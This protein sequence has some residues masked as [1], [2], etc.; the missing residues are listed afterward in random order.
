MAATH[1]IH[2]F[3]YTPDTKRVSFTI[4]KHKILLKLNQTWSKPFTLHLYKTEQGPPEGGT[5]GERTDA[6]R[7]WN[8][9]ETGFHHRRVIAGFNGLERPHIRTQLS[10]KVGIWGIWGKIEGG[11][12]HFSYLAQCLGDLRIPRTLLWDK[13]V[14]EWNECHLLF[15]TSPLPRRP[16]HVLKAPQVCKYGKTWH[17]HDFFCHVFPFWL[18]GTINLLAR[19]TTGYHEKFLAHASVHT[20]MHKSKDSKHERNLPYIR[21]GC[22][23]QYFVVQ[24]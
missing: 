9:G 10:E 3:P 17:S 13:E 15:S 22:S 1:I 18:I 14:K 5:E 21:P 6:Q 12:F 11:L 16:H 19:Q 20:L 4:A 24:V 2:M 8:W 7:E 23:P